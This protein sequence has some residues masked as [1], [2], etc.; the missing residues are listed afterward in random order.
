MSQHTCHNVQHT[1]DNGAQKLNLWF[2][3]LQMHR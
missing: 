3:L 2:K 1:T